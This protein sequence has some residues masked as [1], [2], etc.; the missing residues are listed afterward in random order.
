[1]YN[2][3]WMV[4]CNRNGFKYV[5]LVETT[6]DRLH[7]YIKT[8]LPDATSYSG[9]SEAEVKSAKTLGMPIYLY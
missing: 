7:G 6:E 9:A 3:V 4:N 1:M 8:E 5:I 2:R